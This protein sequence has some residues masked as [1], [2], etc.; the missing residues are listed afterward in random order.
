MNYSIDKDNV[1]IQDE[2]DQGNPTIEV[3]SLLAIAARMELLGIDD[4]GAALDVARGEQNLTSEDNI[5]Q[6]VFLTMA[7]REDPIK[8]RTEAFDKL[9]VSCGPDNL[10]MSQLKH[11]LSTQWMPRIDA[12]RAQAREDMF[13]RRMN[14]PAAQ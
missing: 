14:T 4:P 13:P 7:R 9:P 5:Y 12:L 8:C 10:A 11:Q 1:L 6:D 2:N 3:I